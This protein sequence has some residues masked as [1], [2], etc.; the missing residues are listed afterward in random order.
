[1]GRKHNETAFNAE[2]NPRLRSYKSY[3]LK[4]IE[5]LN[6]THNLRRT[7]TDLGYYVTLKSFVGPLKNPELLFNGLD[8]VQ[9]RDMAT[10]VD[11][12]KKVHVDILF[13]D[14]ELGSPN[15]EDYDP[16]M[17]KEYKYIDED[18]D[19]NNYLQ[20]VSKISLEKTKLISAQVE[21]AEFRNTLQNIIS[22]LKHHS[23]T[24]PDLYYFIPS[25]EDI[26]TGSI[27]NS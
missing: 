22:G 2:A 15:F 5:T 7:S 27:T 12:Y 9:A 24:L 17:D 14:K 25:S 23:V 21:N 10:T 20:D 8:D 6:S 16:N 18:S 3:W 13:E 11:V 26:A 19:F 4:I 1:M